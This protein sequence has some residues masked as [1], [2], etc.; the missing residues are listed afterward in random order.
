MATVRTLRSPGAA[1]A[2][3]E[4]EVEK[5]TP[6][7]ICYS[8]LLAGRATGV[9]TSTSPG[10]NVQAGLNVIFPI[11]FSARRFVYIFDD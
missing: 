4:I 9:S 8:N 2:K 5:S 10:Q 6:Y 11:Q 3:T 1:E 7:P